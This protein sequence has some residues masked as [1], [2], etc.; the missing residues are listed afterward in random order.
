MNCKFC[1]NYIIEEDMCDFCQFEY[2]HASVLLDNWSIF[3]LDADGESEWAHIQILDRLHEKGIECLFA[4]IWYNEN[5]AFIIG[6][7]ADADD[8]AKA[9]NLHKECVYTEFEH[10]MVILNLFQEKYLNGD[11]DEG[12]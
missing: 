5:I 3:G 10:G 2:K 6:A 4:D 1:K 12:E 9:L 11:L 8:I 7:K